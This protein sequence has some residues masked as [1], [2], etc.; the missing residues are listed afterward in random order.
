M[1]RI[2]KDGLFLMMVTL[3]I[4]TILE[5]MLTT[6][7]Q[8]VD[9]AMVGHLGAD[10]TAAV[11]VTTTVSW[12]VGSI[13]SALSVGVIAMVA[14][15]VGSEDK[16][17]VQKT[18]AQAFLLVLLLGV[19][20]TAVVLGISP[21]VPGWMGAQE[22]I[23]STA[24]RYFFIINVPLIFRMANS[25]LAAAIRA[26]KDTKT[27]MLIHLFSNILN[28]VFNILFI[29]VLELGV[30]GA[31]ISTAIS[32]T[33]SG[34][35]IFIVYR[36]K[37]L[38]RWHIAGLRPNGK[39]LKRMAEISVPVLCTSVTSCLGYVVF[40]SLVTG[41][42]NLVFAAHSIAVTAETI[43]YIP[44]YGLR[45]ATQTLIGIS[46]GERDHAKFL[47]VCRYSII[48]TIG[49]MVVSG[50]VLFGIAEPFMRVFT[51]SQEVAALG[52]KMLR[53]VAFSEP[54]FGLMIVMEGIFY[55]LGKTKYVFVVE[56]ASMWC[57]R[58]LFTF[59]MVRVFHGDLRSVW[60]CMIADNVV[61]SV[62]LTIPMLKEKCM[63]DIH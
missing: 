20:A 16:Q 28:V 55:G 45:T 4:P 51:S 19:L 59:L 62:V 58:I 27:P 17:K 5:E 33:I 18:S 6:V 52:A 39:I 47:R 36:K 26:T 46:L 3:A 40:A 38:L 15:G 56:T 22:N 37:E 14:Q 54:F 49:M 48:L 35:L 41:M 53:L 2:Q 24:S 30:E 61:K 1:K 8:Y 31:A 63:A 34:I 44:G 7:M 21:Y 42:G 50:V 10:A 29:Y 13:A 32:Y 43:F 11:S 25:V 60:Y 57:V 9:T 12:L 23:R